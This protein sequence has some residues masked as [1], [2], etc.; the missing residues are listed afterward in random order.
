MSAA[1]YVMHLNDYNLE[2]KHIQHI[3]CVCVYLAYAIAF[4]SKHVESSSYFDATSKSI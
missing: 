2:S 4:H 3:V 1:L